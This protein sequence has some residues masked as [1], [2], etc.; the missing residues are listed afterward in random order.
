LNFDA[1]GDKHWCAWRSVTSAAL[2]LPKVD[3]LVERQRRGGS[4]AV[5]FRRLGKR[6]NRRGALA[7]WHENPSLEINPLCVLRTDDNTSSDWT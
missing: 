4:L 6:S 5:H 7:I 2:V 1:S 3:V